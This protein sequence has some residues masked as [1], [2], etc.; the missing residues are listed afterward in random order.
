MGY[1]AANTALTIHLYPGLSETVAFAAEGF[2]GSDVDLYG[3]TKNAGRK[4]RVTAAMHS[5]YN[6]LA[7]AVP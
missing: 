5:A 1:D 2:A 7:T 6:G 4:V 3:S